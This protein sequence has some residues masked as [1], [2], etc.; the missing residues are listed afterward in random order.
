MK[1]Q[2]FEARKGQVAIPALPSTH[3]L[4]LDKYGCLF[5]PFK[6]VIESL[7]HD[8]HCSKEGRYSR[9]C[10]RQDCCLRGA[11]IPKQEG[12]QIGR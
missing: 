3:H 8:K 5:I 6:K 2:G 1:K 12:R 11:L 10:A 7:L 4:P 9:A